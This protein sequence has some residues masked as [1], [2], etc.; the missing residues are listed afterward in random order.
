MS[1]DSCWLLL[2]Y[3][4]QFSCVQTFCLP[5]TTTSP[6]QLGDQ[7]WIDKKVVLPYTHL[8]GN[9]RLLMNFQQFQVEMHWLW[10][11]EKDVYGCSL[12]N[13]LRII[14]TIFHIP[15]ITQHPGLLEKKPFAQCLHKVKKFGL[16]LFRLCILPRVTVLW[17]CI[18]IWK[19]RL[20]NGNYWVCDNGRPVN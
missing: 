11:S 1:W 5:Y 6:I 13:K 14:Y 17:Y 3:W 15:N 19:K 4:N 8:G 20:H 12:I 10:M 18:F 2:L 7:Y 16:L 9:Q